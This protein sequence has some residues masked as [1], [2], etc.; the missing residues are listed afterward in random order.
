MTLNMNKK[1]FCTIELNYFNCS[2]LKKFKM[3]NRLVFCKIF[4][5]EL[6]DSSCHIILKDLTTL[7]IY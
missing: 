2:R 4:G 5:I 6:S 1:I 3:K 7:Y